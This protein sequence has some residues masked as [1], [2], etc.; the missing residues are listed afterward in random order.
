M[1]DKQIGVLGL[2]QIVAF[3]FALEILTELLVSENQLLDGGVLLPK[4]DVT[5]LIAVDNT[6][7]LGNL[8]P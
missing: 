2:K 1:L 3:D 6:L 7:E 8:D 4:V 5:L